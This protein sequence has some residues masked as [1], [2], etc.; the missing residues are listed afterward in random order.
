MPLERINLGTLPND[1]TGDPLRVAFD[2]INNNFATISGLATSGNIGAIQLAANGGQLGSNVNFTFDSTQT[3]GI[4]NLGA[5]VVQIGSPANVVSAL[6]LSSGNS[7]NVGNI[8]FA[9]NANNV[10]SFTINGTG[11]ILSIP[12]VPNTPADIKVGNLIVTGNVV[13]GGTITGSGENGITGNL[14]V[15][16]GINLTYLTI[17]C[18]QTSTADNSPN[19][20]IFQVPFSQFNTGKFEITSVSTTTPDTQSVTLIMTKNGSNNGT[21]FTAFGTLFQ[22]NCLTTYNTGV[23]PGASAQATI[24]ISPLANIPMQHTI[25]YQLDI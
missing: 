17:N 1:G 9:A 7:L 18:I 11:N 16:G 22:G 2:K 6:W 12:Q 25:S 15:S 24:T 21:V 8:N 13:A 10:G 19:Q 4:L 20:V 3:P 5:N 23:I 14:T